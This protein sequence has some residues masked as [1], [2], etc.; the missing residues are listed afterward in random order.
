MEG[1]LA[2]LPLE[3]VARIIS[4]FETARTL[5]Y[6]SLACRRIYDYVERDGFRIF[7][8][9][10]FPSIKTPPNW[11]PAAHAMTTLSRNWDRRAFVARYLVPR[12]RNTPPRRRDQRGHSP[13]R[14][15]GAQT[16]AYRP[17][18]DSYE[19]WMG[20]T[21][22]SRKQILAWGAGPELI[23]RSKYMGDMAKKHPED[24]LD[25][26][27]TDNCFAPHAQISIWTSYKANGQLEGRDDITCLNLLPSL[28]NSTEDEESIVVGRASGALTL[29]NVG[30]LHLQSHIVTEF[31]TAQRPVR[32]ATANEASKPLLAVCLSNRSLALYSV[33]ANDRTTKPSD[34]TLISLP[35]QQGKTWST[36]FL[37]S[38]RLAVG[39]G[40]SDEPIQVYSI[41]PDGLSE[42]PLRRFGCDSIVTT[43]ANGTSVTSVYSL[44]PIATSSSAGGA[45]GDLFLSGAHDGNTRQVQP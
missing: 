31:D 1:T 10:C 36:K 28:N 13:E 11:K 19:E 34:E 17:V 9:T 22:A 2:T 8:Q 16:I 42:Y 43:A 35:N 33:G 4:C 26:R 3:I 44:A 32:L 23:I 37:R 20:G 6:F 7:V 45:E 14:P 41:E 30:T 39:V 25:V 38:D 21:W 5:I 29:L 40:P 12:F 24:E 15:P 18:I 27:R